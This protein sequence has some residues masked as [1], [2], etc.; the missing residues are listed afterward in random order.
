MNNDHNVLFELDNDSCI[1]KDKQYKV[2]TNHYTKEKYF[3]VPVEGAIF[4]SITKGMYHRELYNKYFIIENKVQLEK[5]LNNIIVDYNE[6]GLLGSDFSY[7]DLRN[8][9]FLFE[10]DL[11][12]Y[13]F[14]YARFIYA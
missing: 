3:R 9:I 6:D 1:F 10:I 8:C 4:Y 7:I 2:F 12:D 14:K 11:K 13:V 5:R